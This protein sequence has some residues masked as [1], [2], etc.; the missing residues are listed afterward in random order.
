MGNDS[1]TSNVCKTGW[2]WV[3]GVVHVSMAIDAV[4]LV[5]KGISYPITSGTNSYVPRYVDSTD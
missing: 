1:L 2:K 5:G 4:H 3:P